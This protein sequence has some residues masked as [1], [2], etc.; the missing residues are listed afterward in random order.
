MASGPT[1]RNVLAG[2]SAGVLITGFDPAS[3]R[4]V[5]GGPVVTGGAVRPAG[6]PIPPLKGRLL[7]CGPALT[8]ASDD[9]GHIVHRRPWAVLQPGDVGD[10]VV[11]LRFCN[12]FGIAAAPRGQGHATFGQA[13]AGS[14]LVIDMSPL[15]AISVGAGA[16]TAQAGSRWSSV[17]Q[18]TLPRGL[19][20]PVLPD[21]LG[22]SVGGTLSAAGV[23]GTSP[24]YGA[25]VDTALELEVVTGAGERAV[26]SRSHRPDLF[27]AVLSGLGQCAV[28]TAATLSVVPAPRR[29]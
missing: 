16:V 5:T 25:Q 19:T 8:A 29:V 21:Y 24:H 15:D 11:M 12:E 7:L 4:W 1:R 28:L 10:I 2:L 3:R 6:R 23:G 22:L 13:Q 26:C 18:A 9:F 17:L 14:G 27:D 20:P